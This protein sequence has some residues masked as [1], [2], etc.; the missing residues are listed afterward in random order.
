M[1]T[2]NSNFNNNNPKQCNHEKMSSKMGRLSDE[3]PDSVD[4]LY[5]SMGTIVM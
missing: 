3:R 5:W 4:A 2:A 1:K